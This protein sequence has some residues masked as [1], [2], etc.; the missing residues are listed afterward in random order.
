M[1]D[2]PQPWNTAA[3]RPQVVNAAARHLHVR[4]Y[5]GVNLAEVDEAVRLSLGQADFDPFQAN[6]P[7]LTDLFTNKQQIFVEFLK[8]L[9]DEARGQALDTLTEALK[10]PDG[11]D[12]VQLAL[13]GGVSTVLRRFQMFRLLVAGAVAEGFSLRRIDPLVFA[14]TRDAV[15][16]FFAGLL[17]FWR[18]PNEPEPQYSETNPAPIW[19]D[20]VYDVQHTAAVNAIRYQLDQPLEPETIVEGL[21]FVYAAATLA[22]LTSRNL[23]IQQ[24]I[25]LLDDL[26]VIVASALRKRGKDDSLLRRGLQIELRVRKLQISQPLKRIIP[27][28]RLDNIGARLLS[29]AFGELPRRIRL[30][31]DI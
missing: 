20:Q 23:D 1:A 28:N 4:G 5:T 26:T 13:H 19:S 12:A 29:F 10:S 30:V 2:G 25:A 24:A 15:H 11:V 18:L 7:N 27:K 8:G 21:F 17:G 6:V 31:H 22:W 14:D 9:L 16:V 3:I